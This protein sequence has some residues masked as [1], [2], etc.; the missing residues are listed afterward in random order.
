[1]LSQ[2]PISADHRDNN[3]DEKGNT[4][5]SSIRRVV[6]LVLALAAVVCA[7]VLSAA[8]ASASSVQPAAVTSKCNGPANY[9]GGKARVCVNFNGIQVNGVA[10]VVNTGRVAVEVLVDVWQCRDS[11]GLD[12]GNAPWSETDQIVPANTHRF[13]A[14]PLKTAARGHYYW[15]GAVIYYWAG[16]V[17]RSLILVTDTIAVPCPC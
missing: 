9:P 15:A 7:F 1:V 4:M 11:A 17:I 14:T 10:D 2:P 5:V 16:A 3:P 8:P 13:P 12:C 6:S